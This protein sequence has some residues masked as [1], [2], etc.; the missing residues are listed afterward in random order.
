MEDKEEMEERAGRAKRGD[1]EPIIF[2]SMEEKSN[3]EEVKYSG[4]KRWGLETEMKEGQVEE[5][6]ADSV[7][8]QF[9]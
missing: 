4:I 1:P 7:F 2:R 9:L 5:D 3:R 8:T 6:E